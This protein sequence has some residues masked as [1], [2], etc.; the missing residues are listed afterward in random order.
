[1]V[2]HTLDFN[3]EAA[4]DTVQNK[5]MVFNN[6]LGPAMVQNTFVFDNMPVKPALEWNG[7]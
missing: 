5:E 4:T 2:L 7:P 6:M 3:A 1:M